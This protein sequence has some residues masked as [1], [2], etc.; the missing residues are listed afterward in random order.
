MGGNKSNEQLSEIENIT[1][2]YKSWEE[3]IKFY[4]NHFKMTHK[5]AYDSKHGKGLKLLTLN[6]YFKDH[7]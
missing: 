5:A 4:N 7:L 2:F 6:K 3:V 1:H